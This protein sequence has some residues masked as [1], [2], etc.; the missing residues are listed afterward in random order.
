MSLLAWVERAFSS[1]VSR[2][3]RAAE[4]P[5]SRPCG[6]VSRETQERGG[7]GQAGASVRISVSACRPTHTP[8]S[9]QVVRRTCRLAGAPF[10]PCGARRRCRA[11]R[12]RRPRTSRVRAVH[13]RPA[14]LSPDACGPVRVRSGLRAARGAC[15]STGACCPA[16]ALSAV[17]T[18]SRCTRAAGC[19]SA[20]CACRPGVRD[21]R[22]ACRRVGGPANVACRRVQTPQGVRAVRRACGPTQVPLDVRVAGWAGRLTC[23][24]RRVHAPHVGCSV[25]AAFGVRP[26]CLPLDVCDA[27]WAGRPTCWLPGAGSPPCT[28]RRGCG[29]PGVRGV[30]RTCRLGCGL[31]GL[32]AVARR[33]GRR[34]VTLTEAFR[35]PSAADRLRPPVGCGG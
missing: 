35:C 15:R 10:D 24:C 32:R 6:R 2:E 21:V 5:S 25:C 27:G 20:R 31:F 16:H 26:A 22:C 12:A 23:A 3:T 17:C 34:R 30:R 28:R 19:A 1:L 8:P 13:V 18:P 14:C 11:P 4:E 9:V 33:A 29:T 7:A